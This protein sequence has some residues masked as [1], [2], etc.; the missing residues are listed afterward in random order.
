MILKLIL[1]TCEAFVS[2]RV[3]QIDIQDITKKA[4]YDNNDGIPLRDAIAL[5]QLVIASATKQSFSFAGG[6]LVLVA[7][8]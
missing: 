6:C 2:Y 7:K 5:Q 4:K 1:K 8:S 3:P